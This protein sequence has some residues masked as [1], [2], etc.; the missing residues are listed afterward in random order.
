MKKSLLIFCLAI[1]LIGCDTLAD[2]N[3]FDKKQEPLPG[4]R[5]SVFQG[6]LQHDRTVPQPF[7]PSAPVDAPQPAKPAK[8]I[9]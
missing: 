3:P 7:N 1:P 8:K 4:Q 5:N 9:Q 2:L 6:G